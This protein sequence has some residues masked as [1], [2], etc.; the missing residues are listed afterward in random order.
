MKDKLFKNLL[1]SAEGYAIFNSGGQL[2]K[3]YKPDTVL[4][5]GE[6]YIIMECDTGTSR[7]G[8]L[9]SML[10]AA[11]YLT[12]EKKGILILVI[13]EKPNTTVKQIAEH[14]REYLAWLKPLTNL[15]IVYLIET[16]KYCPD[17]IPLKLLSSEF[18][19]CAIKIKAE[20]LK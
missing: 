17:K 5:C 16:T 19:K 18:E 6:D 9:G 4:K 2:T 13:K 12:K 1:H 14:L 15:R 3:G 10:K 8:Y 7:K 11:R 20:I